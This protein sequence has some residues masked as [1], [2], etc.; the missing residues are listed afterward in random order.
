VTDGNIYSVDLS[1][2]SS[3]ALTPPAV[4]IRDATG[5]RDPSSRALVLYLTT[6]NGAWKSANGGQSWT[7]MGSLQTFAPGYT[8]I[9]AAEKNPRV[10][11]IGADPDL[12]TGSEY[13]ILK[14]TDGGDTW[15]WVDHVLNW[16]DPQNKTLGWLDRDLPGWAGQPM[17]GLSTNTTGD[18]TYV[19]DSG[20]AFRTLDG[21][22]TWAAVYS[23]EHPDYSSSSR[24]L[25]VTTS[26]AVH[27]D[28]F[29]KDHLVISYTD[30]GPFQSFNGGKS[31]KRMVAGA[32][33]A[34]VN[35]SYWVAFDPDVKNRAWSVWSGAHDLPRPKMFKNALAQYY[36]GG[37]CRTDSPLMLWQSCSN[38][39]GATTHVI[40]DPKSP[41]DSRA[42]YATTFGNSGLGSPAKPG[43][44]YKSTDGGRTW[45]L[46]NAGMTGDN[47]NAWHLVQLPGGTLY[48]LIARGLVPGTQTELDGA[49]YR[50]DDGAE[51]WHPVPLPAGANAPNDLAFD[52]THPSRMYLACWPKTVNGTNQNGGLFVTDDAGATWRLAYD[53]NPHV[54]G[55]RSTRQTR[56]RCSS[57]RSRAP[58]CDRTIAARRGSGWAATTSS[59]GTGPCPIRST[60]GCCT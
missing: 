33:E 56:P 15:A 41:R 52:P 2:S 31:W 12:A 23:N 20:T 60:T 27:F 44:V 57:T 47:R 37:V 34:W 59:G 40:V 45:T 55:S 46:K 4:P 28:P 8:E 19:T 1:A 54:Y 48:V 49:I 7:A 17:Y 26:Y 42:L 24:G 22:V 14:S 39:L 6:D 53:Q 16:H 10:V 51:H 30:I 50:S 38:D 21:G 5:A 9:T 32:P 25:D 29:N 35:T 18:A 43:G 58:H 36:V 3:R 11:Y 13:G